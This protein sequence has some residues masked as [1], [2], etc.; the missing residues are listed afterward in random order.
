VLSGGLNLFAFPIYVSGVG[1]HNVSALANWGYPTLPTADTVTHIGNKGFEIDVRELWVAPD[2]QS[3]GYNGGGGVDTRI[4][5]SVQPILPI[6]PARRDSLQSSDTTWYIAGRRV[7]NSTDA[8]I[9]SKWASSYPGVAEASWDDRFVRNSTIVATGAFT[10][11][12]NGINIFGLQLN[13]EID[14]TEF[15]T[16]E[17]GYLASQGQGT[18]GV[19][20]GSSPWRYWSNSVVDTERSGREMTFVPSTIAGETTIPWSQHTEGGGSVNYAGLV[21]FVRGLSVTSPKMTPRRTS[22]GSI[23]NTENM[24]LHGYDTYTYDQ[25]GFSLKVFH[26][27]PIE[28]YTTTI[29]AN[30]RATKAFFV[31]RVL[32]APEAISPTPDTYYFPAPQWSGTYRAS[33]PVN[34]NGE[35]RRVFTY[36][37]LASKYIQRSGGALNR[38]YLKMRVPTWVPDG[39][40][41]PDTWLMTV[42][43]QPRGLKSAKTGA[44]DTDATMIGTTTQ[45][46]DLDAR[47]LNQ[48]VAVGDHVT[49]KKGATIYVGNVTAV[50]QTRITMSTPGFAVGDDYIEYWVTRHNLRGEC[51]GDEWFGGDAYRRN[52][53]GCNNLSLW[54]LYGPIPAGATSVTGYLANIN[55]GAATLGGTTGVI[56]DAWEGIPANTLWGANWYSPPVLKWT[57]GVININSA[58][59]T[60]GGLGGPLDWNNM[61]FWNTEF[62][63]NAFSTDEAVVLMNFAL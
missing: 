20:V 50:T 31:E 21:A 9:T 17:V 3:P 46:E 54:N 60:V 27:G 56:P 59:T 43:T 53:G 15:T 4:T 25:G 12:Q 11:F 35:M 10:G 48:G 38:K 49:T 36:G 63:L 51:Y 19:A 47:F 23:I 61:N 55:P 16:F 18:W 22:D 32:N 45:F 14:D 29:T 6:D 42:S 62:S 37:A 39:T 44:H 33:L 13:A 28:T 8:E 2:F 24:G 7:P 34:R 30:T 26:I 5:I 52:G 40:E 58:S 41:T 1:Y 57:Y